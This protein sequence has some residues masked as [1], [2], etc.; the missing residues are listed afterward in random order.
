MLEI[1]PKYSPKPEY[2]QVVNQEIDKFGQQR[3]SISYRPYLG[4]YDTSGDY[5]NWGQHKR[6]LNAKGRLQLD[7]KGIPKIK[8]DNDYYYNP[9]TVCQYA[10]TIHGRY[11]LRPRE[12]HQFVDAANHLISMQDV[13]GA[14][15]YPFTFNYYRKEFQPGWVSGM[16][17]GHALSVYARAY[18]VTGDK[19]YLQAGNAAFK[20]LL[21]SVSQGGTMTTM[22]D[23]HPSLDKYIIFEEYPVEPSSYTL[24]GF[25]FTLL[26]IYDWWKLVPDKNPA[27]SSLAGTYFNSCIQTVKHIL[28]YF[29][30][31]GYTAYDLRHIIYGLEPKSARTYHAVHIYLLYALYSITGDRTLRDYYR[32][33]KSYVE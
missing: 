18:Y 20:F 14:F 27:S 2:K 8:Y 3:L 19:R 28:Q 6:F 5:L 15:R 1:W 21:T 7:S 23:L 10:L 13:T 16:S 25:L 26:G 31:G 9:V 12:L 30:L 11:K 22:K 29:D 24:N 17:Q 4:K 33:W 32:L